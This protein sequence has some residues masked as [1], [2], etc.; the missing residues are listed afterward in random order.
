MDL[1]R[2]TVIVNAM[3]DD[4]VG[5]AKGDIDA[6]YLDTLLL[7]H[8]LTLN[9]AINLEPQEKAPLAPISA[10]EV[11]ADVILPVG[12]LLTSDGHYYLI[13]SEEGSNYWVAAE[14]GA[15]FPVKKA[16]VLGK[17]KEVIEHPLYGKVQIGVETGSDLDVVFDK[18]ILTLEELNEENGG[19]IKDDM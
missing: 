2:I 11:K 10:P 4:L 17:F 7:N 18:K 8:V 16:D 3:R 12:T 6:D 14:N 1:L 9:D 13:S 19:T 5:F 15:R